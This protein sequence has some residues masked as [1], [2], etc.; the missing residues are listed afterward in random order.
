MRQRVALYLISLLTPATDRE[1]V[2]GDTV[3][4][5]DHISRSAGA[6]A[7][8]GWLWRE[9]WRVVWHAARHRFSVPRGVDPAGGQRGDGMMSTLWQDIRYGLRLLGRSPGFAAIAIVTLALGI[10]ANTAMFA[11]V[12]AVLLKRLPFHEPDRLMLVHLS[13]PDRE[14][15]GTFRDVV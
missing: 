15:P 13:M 11:V 2:I 9:L 12:N 8:R 4:E 5:F 14:A 10:G 7:A 3:E 6:A 1:W